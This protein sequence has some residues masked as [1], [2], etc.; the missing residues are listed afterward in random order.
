MASNWKLQY[1]SM[2]CFNL[3]F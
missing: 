3:Y 1:F 2:I